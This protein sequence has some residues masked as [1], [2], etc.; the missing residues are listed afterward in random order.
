MLASIY[1]YLEVVKR[2]TRLIIITTC[3]KH[4]LVR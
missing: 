3:M 1:Y 2:L 4:H